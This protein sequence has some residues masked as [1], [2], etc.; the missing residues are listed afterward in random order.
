MT[1]PRH[2]TANIKRHQNEL[3][4]KKLARKKIVR[5]GGQEWTDDAGNVSLHSIEFGPL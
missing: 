2:S 5:E 1:L 4:R 3:L